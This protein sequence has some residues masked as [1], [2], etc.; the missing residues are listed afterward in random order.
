M[1][2]PSE[3]HERLTE[4]SNVEIMSFSEFPST[5]RYSTEVA[6][7]MITVRNSAIVICS[8]AAWGILLGTLI[9]GGDCHSEAPEKTGISEASNPTDVEN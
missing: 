3:F 5:H 2:S 4:E 1:R 8:L 9:R 7:S 6:V